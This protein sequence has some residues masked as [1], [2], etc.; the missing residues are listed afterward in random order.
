MYRCLFRQLY[1]RKSC[2][3]TYILGCEA[4]REAVVIDSV[5]ENVD[6]DEKYLRELD[7]NLKFAL[8]THVHADHISGCGLLAQRFPGCKTVM[9]RAGNDGAQHDLL[10]QDGD[11]VE[12]GSVK[13]TV[14]HT[15]GHTA[16][17]HS[18]VLGDKAVF[19]G[20][21]LFIRGCGRTDFQSGSATALYRSVHDK[22]F[23]LPPQC[24]IHPA[25]DYKGMTIT[26]VG[27]ESR[28]NP[29]LTKSEEEFETLMKGLNLALPDMIDKAVPANLKC[30][31]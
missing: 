17:C 4:T 2:T 11:V 21:C 25:H 15:P 22:I 9:G 6:R 7:M 5:L 29:R 26:T 20:D 13:L 1:D 18:F 23:S 14:V 8:E 27:E 19:T 12:C 24:R 10:L 30:G 31:L 28:W 3:F 16:G